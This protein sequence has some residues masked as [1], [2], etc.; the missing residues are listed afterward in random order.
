ML[1]YAAQNLCSISSIA[2]VCESTT[3]FRLWLLAMKYCS[4]LNYPR[5]DLDTLLSSYCFDLLIVSRVALCVLIGFCRVRS[6][7]LDFSISALALCA[8]S[9]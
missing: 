5:K 3:P 7:E 2:R 4:G 9:L 1:A 8:Y 6:L